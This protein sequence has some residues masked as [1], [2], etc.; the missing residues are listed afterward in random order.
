MGKW[1]ERYA[2]VFRLI[3][4]LAV[5]I[6]LLDFFFFF[7]SCCLHTVSAYYATSIGWVLAILTT[8]KGQWDFEQKWF[9][10][11]FRFRNLSQRQSAV[12]TKEIKRLSIFFA[13]YPSFEELKFDILSALCFLNH[14]TPMEGCQ[15]QLTSGL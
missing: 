7:W 10:I 6:S 3:I 9:S 1:K 8:G 15:L 4:L 5:I 12:N 11:H 14:S 2:P 13:N